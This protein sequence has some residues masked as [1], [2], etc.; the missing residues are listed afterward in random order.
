M[1]RLLD[2]IKTHTGATILICALFFVVPLVTVH[3]LFKIPAWSDCL[4]AVWSAV[5]L[6][7]YIAGFEALIGTVFLAWLRYTRPKEQMMLLSD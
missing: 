2:W 6:L 3:I 4:V 1:K 5:E 7:A